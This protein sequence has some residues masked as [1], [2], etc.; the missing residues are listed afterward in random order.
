M[1]SE[2]LFASSTCAVT[3]AGPPS[4][5]L[6]VVSPPLPSAAG[7]ITLGATSR[8]VSEKGGGGGG[9]PPLPSVPEATRM[10]GAAIVQE[11]F[12]PPAGEC[13][14]QSASVPVPRPV[15][16]SFPD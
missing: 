10:P 5:K 11:Y 2:T 13:H 4:V 6:T 1:P 14:V 16:T 15:A 7:A 9:G 8:F 12:P 3:R